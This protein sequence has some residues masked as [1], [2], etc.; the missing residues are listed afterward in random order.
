[1]L[2]FNPEYFA[3]SLLSRRALSRVLRKERE[4]AQAYRDAKD[5]H[6]AQKR[7][8][9]AAGKVGGEADEDG[10]AKEEEIEGDAEAKE[11]EE[12]KD[13]DAAEEEEDEEE[14]AAD[15]AEAIKEEQEDEEERIKVGSV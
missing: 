2:P 12:E 1:L 14:E 5:A 3:K 13:G 9:V 4:T 8:G 11:E 6:R 15:V 7:L 10:E